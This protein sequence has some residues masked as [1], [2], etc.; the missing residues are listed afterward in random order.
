VIGWIGVWW[1]EYVLFTPLRC[2]EAI[3]SV[4]TAATRVG[5]EGK[6]AAKTTREVQQLV[7]LCSLVPQNDRPKKRLQSVQPMER[8][9][10][11]TMARYLLAVL[12]NALREPSSS[13][14]AAFDQAI[15]WSRNKTDSLWPVPTIISKN[16]P[17]LG[18]GWRSS[19]CLLLICG[20]I[21][22]AYS[23]KVTK[24]STKSLH[25]HPLKEH[26]TGGRGQDNDEIDSG[27]EE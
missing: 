26:L 25:I 2:K 10:I 22:R 21:P 11:K 7:A 24:G 5:A 27:G 14:R 18:C 20:A 8:E 6:L 12:R 19:K 23:Y 15:R 9:E 1:E 16:Q 13:Q 4:P 17:R 3:E